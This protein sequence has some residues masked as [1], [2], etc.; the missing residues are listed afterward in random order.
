PAAIRDVHLVRGPHTTIAVDGPADLYLVVNDTTC[1]SQDTTNE[2][3]VAIR[4]FIGVG[5]AAQSL[6]SRMSHATSVIRARVPELMARGEVL[7]SEVTEMEL[8]AKLDAINVPGEVQVAVD[9]YPA[10]MRDLFYKYIA[11]E[12]TQLEASVRVANIDRE[13]RIKDAEFHATEIAVQNSAMDGY[14]VSL[15]PRWTVRGLRLKELRDVTSLYA[16]DVR[17]YLSP[18]M[19][20]WY[21][22]VLA[23]LDDVTAVQDLVNVDVDRPVLEMTDRLLELGTAL[24]TRIGNVDTPY[25]SPDDTAPSFVAVR[26]PAPAVLDPA[27]ADS[28]SARCRR[29][30]ESST[31]RWATVAQSKALWNALGQPTDGKTSR[32]LVFELGPE[33][34]YEVSSGSEYLSCT[35]SLPVVRRMGLALTGFTAS[36]LPGDHRA[37]EGNIPATAPM[38]FVDATGVTSFELANPS[39]RNL[40]N[41]PLVYGTSDYGKV[42]TDFTAIPQDVRGVS[43]FTT[44]VFDIP[45]ATV[46]EWNLRNAKTIDLVLELE[47]VRANAR[48][49]VPA[50][51][52]AP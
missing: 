22:Q 4:R 48:V 37:I 21:P 20:V 43:P 25:P 50:C 36:S 28:P 2:L 30:G 34:V 45:E 6:L 10:P 5:N 47:A 39:W 12:M 31:Y 52:A 44:F 35:K 15:L 9:D 24:S 32:H 1:D 46:A 19:R 13:M 18:L 7:P 38:A 49:A 33:D 41:V 11:R 14:L 51:S 27:C 17:Y 42:K 3:H 26:F 40:A 8:S 16:T 29:V 23:G